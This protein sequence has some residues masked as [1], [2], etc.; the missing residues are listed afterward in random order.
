MKTVDWFENETDWIV[1]Q[2]VIFNKELVRFSFL[3]VRKL[4]K[5]V[6]AKEN[7]EVLD[8][9]CGIGRHSIEFAK[10]GMRVTGVDLTETY[11][12]VA[13]DT[14]EKAKLSIRFLQSDMRDFI[15]RDSFDVV[16]NLCTSFGYFEEIKDDIK[17]LHNVY[18]SLR[19]RGKFVIE[20]L[21]K[22]VIAAQFEPKQWLEYEGCTVL[23]K[24]RILNDWTTLECIRT[25]ITESGRSDVVS[26][27]R[28]YSAV[29]LRNIMKDVG[30]KNIETFGDFSGGPYDNMAKS[31]ILIGTK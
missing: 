6:G 29:E 31:L 28:L 12:E 21:G 13:R 3:E 4:L 7:L 23:S 16:V 14:A 10:N 17:V 8:L 9:C 5:L 20:I 19:S 24:S 18:D 25:V 27:H 22:E 11:L 1:K 30:F 26:Y 15:S 2:S